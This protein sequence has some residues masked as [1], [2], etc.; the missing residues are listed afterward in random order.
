MIVKRHLRIVAMVLA[1]SL[2]RLAARG[3]EEAALPQ[4]K[5]VPRMQ[6]IPLPEAQASFQ[7]DG[8]ELTRAYFGADLRRPFLFPGP[9]SSALMSRRMAKQRWRP[10]SPLK[11]WRH[12]WS[13]LEPGAE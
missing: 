9:R 2:P 11:A 1:A 7:R 12:R 8:A 6:V 13:R 10:S 3:A 5:P 4:S